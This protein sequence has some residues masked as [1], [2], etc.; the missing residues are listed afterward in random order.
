MSRDQRRKEAYEGLIHATARL[1]KRGEFEASKMLE[2]LA[3]K[4]QQ[5]TP[6]LP[7]IERHLGK[8]HQCRVIWNGVPLRIW[9]DHKA[10]G[11]N[12]S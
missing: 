7:S 2:S 3:E 6:T 1:W 11:P 10:T 5:E 12:G 8:C 4:M 9:R